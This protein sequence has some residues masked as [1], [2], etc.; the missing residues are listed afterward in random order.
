VTIQQVDIFKEVGARFAEWSHIAVV[1]GDPAKFRTQGEALSTSF[2]EQGFMT[3]YVF[4]Y[5]TDW[6][7]IVG[8]MDGLR[9]KKRRVIYV[10][11]SES[12]FRKIVCAS[13][14]VKANTGISWLSEGSWRE[15]WY[16]KSDAI[17]ES[18]KRWTEENAKSE[19]VRLAVGHFKRDWDL[20]AG[21][22]EARFE[23]LRKD[24]V[25]DLREALTFVEGDSGYHATH[26][27]WHPI[28]RA[29]AVNHNYFDAFL[30]DLRG[31]A[32]YTVCKETDFATNFG[33]KRSENLDYVEWQ[34]S[35]LGTA[36]TTAMGE[37]D[38]VSVT[39]WTPYG[40]SAGALAAFLATGIRDG[41]GNLLGIYSTQMPTESMSIDNY[42]PEC[43]LQAISE[44]F[45]GAINVVGLG[46]PVDAELDTQVPCFTGRTAKAFLEVLDEA[47]TNGYPLSDL[48]TQVPDPY[49]DLKTHAADG[50][51]VIAYAL[52]HL[53]H[54]QGLS[55][56]DIREHTAEAYQAFVSYIKTTVDFQGA[57]GRVRFV[58]NDKPA[59]LAVQQVQEG[60]TVLVG[61]CTHNG[62]IDFDVN[63]GPS[64]ASWLPA[65]PDA[66][67]AKMYF[68][69]WAFQICLPVCFIITGICNAYVPIGDREFGKLA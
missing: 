21:S 67:P 4:A 53:M 6:T 9:M 14:V 36:F 29:L 65:Y 47:L 12:Y 24:Y 44:S 41:E 58:A 16:A 62:T 64:N 7:E 40:P 30:F 11:G 15:G 19:N 17:I 66:I 20:I 59:Y 51:C 60:V 10:M 48:D 28:F 54:V 52:K 18:Q 68:P 5:D 31:N 56:Y 8:L 2:T 39:D 35:A 42:E 13:I 32:I 22:D 34:K 1:S 3:N 43:T 25:T 63:G 37:P 55:L 49:H 23:I 50:I 61:T 69:Y 46:R 45:E 38:I 33:T 26:K 27:T 57:S